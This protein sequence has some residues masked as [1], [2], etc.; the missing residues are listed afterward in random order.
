MASEMQDL[1]DDMDEE[2]E[3]PGLEMAVPGLGELI[4]HV[5]GTL[6]DWSD[7]ER[8]RVRVALTAAIVGGLDA[9]AAWS[10]LQARRCDECRA[11]FGRID[12]EA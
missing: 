4:G 10:R 2:D 5:A 3:D 7:D 12:G 8:A 6:A 9:A 11:L 1:L